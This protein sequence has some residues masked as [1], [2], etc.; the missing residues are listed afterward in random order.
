MTVY[1][2][3][4]LSQALEDLQE[5]LTRWSTIASDTLSI[6]QDTQRHAQE[7]VDQT[8]HRAAIVMDQAE[9]DQQDVNAAADAVAKMLDK[10]REAKLVSHKT[11]GEANTALQ[12]ANSTLHLWEVELE[13]ALAW[14]KRAEARLAKAEIEYDRAERARDAAR[15]ELNAAERSYRNCQNDKERSDCSS[16]SRRVQRAQGEL[17]DAEH[18]L[19]LAYVELMAAR[20]EVRQ[21][22]ARVACCQLAVSNSQQAFVHAQAAVQNANE[23]VNA[24]ER[25]LEFVQAAE[26]AIRLAQ[27]HATT[28]KEVADQ[29]NIAVQAATELTKDA[30][31]HFQLAERTETSAQRQSTDVRYELTYR[32]DQLRNLNRV[33]SLDS[34]VSSNRQSNY[35]PMGVSA[36]SSSIG[37]GAA[38][39]T[40]QPTGSTWVDSGTN[41]VPIAEL[42]DPQDI[43]GE[44]DFKKVPMTEMK[45]GLEKLQE[46]LPIVERGEGTSKDYWASFDTQKGLDYE[47]G[48]QRIYEAFY[49][50][51]AIRLNH[52][53]NQYDIVNGRHRIWLAKRMGITNLPARVIEKK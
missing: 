9:R 45:A 17:R 12:K 44:N 14:L 25:S 7:A 38:L 42:P 16:E 46:M 27:Q 53:G 35:S 21:A 22:K 49:G 41:Y 29:M 13:K 10:A 4:I 40:S 47:H 8:A 52:N 3:R 2:P 28:E 50:D 37:S 48:Y 20:E 11:L 5:E 34:S 18:R 39:S 36:V 23:A 31:H 6:A 32:V 24:A 15:Q 30:F 19:H 1:D 26:R 43:N 33:V 51:D